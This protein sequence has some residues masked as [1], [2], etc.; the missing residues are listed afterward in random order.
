MLLTS[1][2]DFELFNTILYGSLGIIFSLMTIFLMLCFI[3]LLGRK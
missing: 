2:F 1:G 3:C